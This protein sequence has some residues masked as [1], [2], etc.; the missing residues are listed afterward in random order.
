M[1]ARLRARQLYVST[2]RRRSD[3]SWQGCCTVAR[4]IVAYEWLPERVE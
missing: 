4:P 1:G 3:P 2:G